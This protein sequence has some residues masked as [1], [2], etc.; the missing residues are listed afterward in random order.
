M[1]HPSDP[2]LGFATRVIAA[3]DPPRAQ[4]APVA[5]PIVQSSTFVID[6]ALDAAMAA[7][8]WRTEYLYSRHANPT[9]DAL[10]GRLAELHRGEDAIA[11]ASG[12]AAVSA[13]LIG[14]TVRGQRVLADVALY[15]ATATF[16]TTYLTAMG[17]EVVMLDLADP[18]ARSAHLRA[19]ESDPAPPLV[20]GETLSNPL[21]RPL[22]LPAVAA[23]TAAIGGTFV[24]DNTFANPLVCR[25]IEHGAHVVIESLSKSIAGHSDVHGGAVV[26]D[27]DRGAKV[28]HAMIHL[29][30]CLDPHAAYLIWRGLKTLAMRTQTAADNAAQLA[31][32]LRG[33][34]GVS[35]VYA[36][37]ARPW[38][39]HAGAML[40]FVVEGGNAAA[41]RVLDGL[42][43]VAPAT[44]LGGVESLASLPY[45]TSHRTAESQ[46]RAGLL[47]G[48]VR[49]SVGCEDAADLAA[50]LLQAVRAAREA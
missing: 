5:L 13:V 45:N 23:A 8:D 11:F 33:M 28:W 22:D 16:L 42:R 6:D 24:V 30:G 38:L 20:Y 19:L 2:K 3:H 1:A 29:G 15:G 35:R 26:T 34:P 17:R 46:A 49:L 41:H 39:A 9:V 27:A 12:M 32:A 36:P 21:C 37:D 4:Q 48:T 44:S 25:P 31:V 14:L 40:A 47:P 18:A 7:G 43:V 50:D 10:A